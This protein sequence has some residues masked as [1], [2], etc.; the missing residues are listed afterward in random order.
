M[1]SATPSPMIVSPWR[2]CAFR[3]AKICSCLR[4][5]GVMFSRRSTRAASINSVA[6]LD[7]SSVRLIDMGLGLGGSVFP[8]LRVLW[9]EGFATVTRV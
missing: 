4:M 7:L 1:I 8:Q 2:A 9:K 6:D 5:R 3:I